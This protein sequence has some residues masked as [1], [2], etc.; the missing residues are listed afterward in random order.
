MLYAQKK[1]TTAPTAMLK[2][3][4]CLRDKSAYSI[5][6]VQKIRN[7]FVENIKK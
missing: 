6:Y 7:L 3:G 4:L 2:K 1:S 5:Q